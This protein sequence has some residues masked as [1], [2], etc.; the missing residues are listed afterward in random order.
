MYWSVYLNTCISVWLCV[1]SMNVSIQ[2][3]LRWWSRTVQTW[4]RL[5]CLRLVMIQ[6]SL[7]QWASPSLWL[8]L[9]WK[10]YKIFWQNPKTTK[11][12]WATSSNIIWSLV[13]ALLQNPREYKKLPFCYDPLNLVLSC[14]CELWCCMGV[15]DC[16]QLGST[17]TNFC[18]VKYFC[19]HIPQCRNIQHLSVMDVINH[20]QSF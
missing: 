2:G 6:T 1:V 7:L 9:S 18:V 15:L 16:S 5:Q 14:S 17:N 12:V 11:S 10:L 13:R 8:T 3:R 20:Y 19:F 4:L